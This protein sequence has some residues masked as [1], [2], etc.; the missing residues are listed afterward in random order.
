MKKILITGIGGDIAQST[1]SII[2]K[3][4]PG[5]LLL[6]TDIHTQHGGSLFVDKVT[7]LPAASSLEYPSALEQF[8]NEEAVDIVYPM[9]EP[10]LSILNPI[11]KK[12]PQ[13]TWVTAGQKVME[14]GV[15][16]LATMNALATLGIATPWTI[17]VNE[18]MPLE[19][20]CILK[21]RYGSGS[22]AVFTI[23][24]ES[25]AAFFK[26]HYP[27]AIYQE[28][29]EPPDREV[30]CAVYRTKDGRVMTLQFLRRLVG[31]FTGW[32][33]VIQDPDVLVMCEQI[34]NGLALAG[35]MNVQLRLTTAG[36]RVFEINPRISS[37]VMMRNLLGFSDVVW[38]L[39]ELAGKPINVPP[40]KVGQVLV[41]VQGARVLIS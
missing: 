31:G 22:R 41:R 12:N 15:D 14:T 40:I 19:Y 35:S 3:H 4:Y 20:P 11:I 5:Y 39:D 10:E 13:I 17:P 32:A 36:P 25:E 7:T 34:A 26:H 16:K 8:L 28:L 29:L 21:N 23:R 9:T 27:D 6:G 33:Q 38:P 1:A 37:T 2:R 18:G 30:T 24:T